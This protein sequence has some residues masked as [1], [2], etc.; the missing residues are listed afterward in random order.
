MI[1]IA[2]GLWKETL[3][4]YLTNYVV[5]SKLHPLPEALVF[6]ICNGEKANNNVSQGSSVGSTR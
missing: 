5:L 4:H 3:P 2:T 6:L 1:Q